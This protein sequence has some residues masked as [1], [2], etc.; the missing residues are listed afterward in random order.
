MTF[1][2]K[3]TIGTYGG[4]LN[5]YAPV[6]DASTDRPASGVNQ[7]YGSVAA[8]THN[9]PRAFCRLVLAATTG[10][11]ALASP[12]PHDAAWG[13]SVGVQPT[14]ARTSAGVFTITWPASV[15]DEIGNSQAVSFR[16]AIGAL[17]GPNAGDIACS[18]TSPNVV[19]L[20]A[21]NV[22]GAANDFAG[23]TASV[24]VF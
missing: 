2:S 18:V 22:A 3:D 24:T 17:E 14:L 11:L 15:T 12:Y 13:N 5:D 9:A 10:A 8:M 4:V 6:V 21:F 20:Y 1:P 16:Y 7:A 19:T 23:V